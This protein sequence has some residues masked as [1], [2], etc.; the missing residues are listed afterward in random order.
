MMFWGEKQGFLVGQLDS[1]QLA[2][3]GRRSAVG[4][5]RQ[6]KTLEHWNIGTISSGENTNSRTDDISFD[7]G[8]WILNLFGI[9]CL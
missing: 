7:F 4:G 6:L 5:R 1:W 8:F 3:S 9:W 2:I